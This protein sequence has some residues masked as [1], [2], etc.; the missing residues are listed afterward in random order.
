MTGVVVLGQVGRDLVLQ[1]TELPGAG[2]SA[3]VGERLE[4]AGGKG[5]NQAVALAQLGLPVALV[6]VVGEDGE[7]LLDRARADGVDVTAVVRRPG[8]PSAL[9]VDVVEADGTR[10]L[11]EDVPDGVLLTAADVAAAGDLLAG[12]AALVLQLQQ[13]G[14]AVRAALDRVGPD[15]LVVADGAPADDGTRDAVLARAAVLRADASEAALLVGRGLDGVGDVRA[16]ARELLAAGPRLVALSAGAD[17]DLVA[18]RGG[19]SPAAGG[20]PW[21]DDGDLLLPLHDHHPADPTGGGDSTVAAL[22]AAVLGGA[23]PEDAARAASAAATLTVGR[24]GGRPALTAA[25]LAAQVAR[26]RAAQA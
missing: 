22:T 24:L 8:V 6:G 20:Q 18:W 13:P 5:A 19:P 25:D 26:E 14:E 2:G 9:L 4:V 21:P 1:V 10:R 12:C 11:L 7:P 17:G 15:A 16:A 3:D 23:T